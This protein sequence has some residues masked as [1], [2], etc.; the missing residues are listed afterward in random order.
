[1][2]NCIC[3]SERVQKM[4]NQITLNVSEFFSK[5]ELKEIAEQELRAAFRAQFQKES[6]VE[7]VIV[8]LSYEYVCKMV[9]EQWDGDF[10]E[11]LRQKVRKTI[12]EQTGWQV[13]RRKDAWGSTESPAVAILDEECR[14]SRPLIRAAIEKHIEEY[15]FHELDKTEIAETIWEVIM[16]K[17]LAPMGKRS[18]DRE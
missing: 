14:N 9:A 10:E 1:M 13:F 7:R 4:D 15:P 18:E 17:I 12:E 6:D 3:R 2:K 11:L 5:E 16:E 8:N